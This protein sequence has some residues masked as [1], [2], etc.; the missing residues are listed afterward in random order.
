MSAIL[1]FSKF[2]IIVGSMVG[3]NLYPSSTQTQ[4]GTGDINWRI[5]PIRINIIADVLD[6][7]LH[8]KKRTVTVISIEYIKLMGPI[9][10]VTTICGTLAINNSKIAA[11]RGKNCDLFMTSSAFLL[12]GQSKH[13]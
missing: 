4:N 12:L 11:A 13:Y 3:Q 2:L 7:S 10:G 8:K 1:Y 5:P 9:T 6:V